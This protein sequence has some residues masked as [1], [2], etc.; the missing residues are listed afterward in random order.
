MHSALGVISYPLHLRHDLMVSLGRLQ[1][2]D[3]RL[4]ALRREYQLQRVVAATAAAL[5]VKESSSQP[6]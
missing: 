3:D 1:H 2:A 4:R 5:L 6:T